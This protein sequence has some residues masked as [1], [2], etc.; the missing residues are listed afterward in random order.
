MQNL[1]VHSLK[2]N[3]IA[4]S[5][6]SVVAEAIHL[7]LDETDANSEHI[8]TSTEEED[9]GEAVINKTTVATTETDTIKWKDIVPW[10]N[11]IECNAQ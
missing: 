2:K 5:I 7:L 6:F 1:E 8:L 4:S 10:T 3:G 9:K 11:P